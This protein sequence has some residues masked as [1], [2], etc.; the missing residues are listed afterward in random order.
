MNFLK[1][2]KIYII[3]IIFIIILTSLVYRKGLNNGLQFERD[4]HIDDKLKVL[5]IK[6][7][8]T[9]KQI[10]SIKSLQSKIYKEKR[11]LIKSEKIIEDSIKKI[12][13]EKSKNNICDELYVNSSKKI[14]LLEKQIFIK[15]SVEYKSNELLSNQ[16][17]IILKQDSAIKNMN[18][19]INLIK[20]KKIK[21]KKFGIGVNIGYGVYIKNKQIEYKP[22]VGLGISYNFLNF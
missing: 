14:N 15:D 21:T 5:V 19:Q 18:S 17:L 10:D 11:I 8:I 20:D 13:I 16:D 12:I 7:K 4:K 9:Q 2:Y 3:V 22:Y 6:S 1:N